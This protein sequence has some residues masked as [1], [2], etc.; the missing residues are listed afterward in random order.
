MIIN[1]VC[2]Q[3]H[4]L[5]GYWFCAVSGNGCEGVS[6]GDWHWLVD[7]VKQCALLSLGVPHPVPRA[8]EQN[9]IAEEE[10]FGSS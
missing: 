3:D 1:F 9:K 4:G 5:P 2:Q 7:L 8:T 6:R 10:E